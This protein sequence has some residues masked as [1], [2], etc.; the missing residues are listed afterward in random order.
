[1]TEQAKYQ[2]TPKALAAHTRV[3]EVDALRGVAVVL[4]V[5]FHL[6]W[7]LQ[8][9]GLAAID[10]F[11]PPWQFFARGIG[12]L[13]TFILGLSMVLRR[14]P[15]FS[16]PVLRRSLL[17]FGLGMIISLATYFLFGQPGYVRFGILHLLGAALL[18]AHPLVFAPPPLTL[19]L[20]LLALAV[21]AYLGTIFVDFPWL[22]WLG[23]PQDGISAVDYYPLLPW[24]GFA[25]LGIAAGRTC[26]GLGVRRSLLP[27]LGE[28]PPLRALRWLGRHALP[29]YLLHQPLLL[30]LLALVAALR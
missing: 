27:G 25:L 11:T 14:A 16:P 18:L 6:S 29:I 1:M 4:M 24:G 15:P 17:L 2:A 26:Y 30:G 19:A 21:G 7:D 20:G 13:F 10:V 5:I 28:A 8:F 9:Y 12:S 3:W 23:L 22:I